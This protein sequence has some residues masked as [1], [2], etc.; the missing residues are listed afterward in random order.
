MALL[1]EGE[2]LAVVKS[3]GAYTVDGNAICCNEEQGSEEEEKVRRLLTL[4][5]A[6]EKNACEVLVVGINPST[7]KPGRSDRTTSIL[8]RV[9][10]TL[11]YD[12]LN[13][14]N[15]YFN[16]DPKANGVDF[17]SKADFNDYKDLFEKADA[18][19]CAW[20]LDLKFPAKNSE[21]LDVLAQY[22]DKLW[23]IER[24]GKFPVHPRRW[25][26]G[27]NCTF[28]KFPITKWREENLGR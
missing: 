3:H 9:F 19:V 20:G 6:G 14:I 13:V 17:A 16:R 24:N 1:K 2:T 18:V 15:L 8:A 10:Y 21:A 27:D 7:A 28:R 5:L 26:Y 22:E 11:G 25:C 23:C 4:P 12:T